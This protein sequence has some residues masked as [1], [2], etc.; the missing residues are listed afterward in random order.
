M[1]VL[2]KKKKLKLAPDSGIHIAKISALKI[3]ELRLFLFFAIQT[4]SEKNGLSINS[5]KSCMHL[6]K[7]E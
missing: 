3:K 2:I 6:K 1:G 4:G 5:E 7:N